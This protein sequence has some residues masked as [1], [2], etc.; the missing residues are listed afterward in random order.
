MDDTPEDDA[1]ENNIADDNM[2]TS[3]KYMNKTDITNLKDFTTASPNK[4]Y[5]IYIWSDA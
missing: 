1:V 5:K 2:S 3:V 4:E